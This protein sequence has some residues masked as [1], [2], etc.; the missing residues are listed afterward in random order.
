MAHLTSRQRIER[1]MEV[2]EI[3]MNFEYSSHKDSSCPP[4]SQRCD[5]TSFIQLIPDGT[6]KNPVIGAGFIPGFALPPG[7]WFEYQDGP[8]ARFFPPSFGPPLCS[9]RALPIG[10]EDAQKLSLRRRIKKFSHT[11]KYHLDWKMVRKYHHSTYKDMK[12]KT[13]TEE[14]LDEYVDRW[15]KGTIE[16]TNGTRVDFIRDLFDSD[17]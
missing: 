1:Y 3:D 15:F 11:C 9:E 7:T 12:D 13:G 2:H 17:I 4:S 14:T 5:L 10:S 8:F 6:Y 16:L